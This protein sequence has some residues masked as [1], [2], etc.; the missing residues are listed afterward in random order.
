MT[1]I[2]VDIWLLLIVLLGG[3]YYD[4]REHRIPNWWILGAVL[5]GMS[6]SAITAPDGETALAAGKYLVR[7]AVTVAVLF[8]LFLVRMVGAGDIK[9]IGVMMAYL[10][11]SMGIRA[12]AYGCI[13]GAVLALTKLLVQRNLRRR[14]TYLFVYFRRLFQTK[15]IVPYYRADRDGYAIVIPFAC[16]LCLGYVW[17]LLLLLF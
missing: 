6:L 13:L 1:G 17:Y 7:L 12:M 2:F 16:C 8:P 4:V 9:M 14:L 15:E 11:F 5:C 3:A 10:G